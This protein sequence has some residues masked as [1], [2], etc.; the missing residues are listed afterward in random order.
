M[1]SYDAFAIRTMSYTTARVYGYLYFYDWINHDPRSKAKLKL[2]N[3]GCK[4]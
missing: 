3:R 2:S 4:T 1:N